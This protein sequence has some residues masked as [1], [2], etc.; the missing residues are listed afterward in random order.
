MKFGIQKRHFPYLKLG[1]NNFCVKIIR[2][3]HVVSQNECAYYAGKKFPSHLKVLVYILYSH[4]NLKKSTSVNDYLRNQNNVPV[5]FKLC[6]KEENME[7]DFLNNAI[8]HRSS[9]SNIN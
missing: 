3:K 2:V 1:K 6:L 4:L 9:H 7:K 8:S 5:I